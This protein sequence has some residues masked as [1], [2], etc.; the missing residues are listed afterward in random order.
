MITPREASSVVSYRR[1]C[2]TGCLVYQKVCYL[3]RHDDVL[4][5]KHFPRYWSFVRGIHRSPVN[6]SLKGQW[7]GALMFSLI[8]VWIN[9]V[10]IQSWGWWF[11][12]LSCPSW[13][14]CN[15][16]SF[17][18][19]NCEIQCIINCF[20]AKTVQLYIFRF[21]H[22]FIKNELTMSVST[23]SNY[24]QTKYQ[25]IW[26]R[27]QDF[28]TN[29]WPYLCVTSD[30]QNCFFRSKHVIWEMTCFVYYPF[31]ENTCPH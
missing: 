10:S 11:E 14:H 13:R 8:C 26:L 1:Y 20:I 31:Y 9:G 19:R 25:F 3:L 16:P 28:L 2:N 4:K 30:D 24:G 18:N 29:W 12:T 22:L 21:T 17:I 5:W 7:R 15:G 27:T 6:S 23:Y